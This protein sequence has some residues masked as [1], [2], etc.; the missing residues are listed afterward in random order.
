MVSTPVDFCW[1]CIKKMAE[2][3]DVALIL[4]ICGDSIDRMDYVDTIGAAIFHFDSKSDPEQ[5]KVIVGERIRLVA[6]LTTS[7]RCMPG[8]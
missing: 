5:A 1:S 2:H 3:L 8:I 7:R 4:H 6:T